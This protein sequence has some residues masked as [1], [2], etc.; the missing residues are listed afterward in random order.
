MALVFMESYPYS[1]I[2]AST[3]SYRKALLNRLH[4]PLRRKLA[5]YGN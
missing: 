3:S 5:I 2:L 4:L 1:L